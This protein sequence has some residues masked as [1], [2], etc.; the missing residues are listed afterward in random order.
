MK[1]LVIVPIDYLPEKLISRTESE[2]AM[3]RN[4]KA[5]NTKTLKIDQ[6]TVEELG[7]KILLMME[8]LQNKV[9]K[10]I[11]LQTN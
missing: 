3:F 8:H 1:V 6:L 11:D 2:S 5:K 10:N 4:A 9:S 7:D